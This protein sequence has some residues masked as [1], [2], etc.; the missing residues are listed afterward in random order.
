MQ[1]MLYLMVVTLA[2][3]APPALLYIMWRKQLAALQRVRVTKGGPAVMW[4]CIAW[5]PLANLYFTV[6]SISSI[7]HFAKNMEVQMEN[8]I[9]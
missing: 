1:A 9:F 2:L 4:A 5:M 8:N 6:K 7:S 3:L